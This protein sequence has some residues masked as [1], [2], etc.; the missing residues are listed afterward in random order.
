MRKAE[1]RGWT[2]ATAPCY[3]EKHHVFIKAIFGENDRVVYLTAREHV[4]A[5]LLLFKAC[6][7][8]YGRHDQRTWKVAGAATA[9]GMICERHWDRTPVTCSTLGLAREVEAENKSINYTGKPCPGRQK[10]RVWWNNGETQTRS[11]V[12]PGEGWVR[13]RLPYVTKPKE[14]R[15]VTVESMESW[16]EAGRKVGKAHADSG[17]WEKVRCKDGRGGAAG[18]GNVWWNNGVICTRAKDCPGEGW[19]RGRLARVK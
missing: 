14:E 18:L 15:V 2:K 17:Q 6:L 5:H 4:I 13:G 19:V 1:Q 12:C 8:R 11:R 10:G 7:K 3:V 16:T 9:M